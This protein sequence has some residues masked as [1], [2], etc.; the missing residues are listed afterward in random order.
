MQSTDFDVI[1]ILMTIN[2]QAEVQFFAA[3]PLVY[4]KNY[5][6]WDFEFWRQWMFV[7]ILLKNI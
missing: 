2:K 5:V 6:K 1:K 4:E 3:L 7:Y